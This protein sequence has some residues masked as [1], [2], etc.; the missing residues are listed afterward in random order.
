MSLVN[1]NGVAY[2]RLF[3]ITNAIGVVG[4][5]ND[6]TSQINVWT[7]SQRVYFWAGRNYIRVQAKS[8]TADT[9]VYNFGRLRIVTEN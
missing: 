6:T 4:S 3:D 8:L 9:A 5:E 7:K 1:G 2:V